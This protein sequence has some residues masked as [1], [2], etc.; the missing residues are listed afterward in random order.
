VSGELKKLIQSEALLAALV[1]LV[2][3]NLLFFPVIWGDKTLI[4]SAGDAASIMP[5]GAY[6]QNKE[7][8]Q[9]R[10]S[11][12]DGAP[13]WF[14]E[15]NY[16]L[17]HDCYFTRS[18]APLWNP[19]NGY[20]TPL[21]ANMQSQPFNPLILLACLQP[22]PRADDLFVLARLLL[23]G[24]LTN[25]YLRR[26]IGAYGAI[27]GA[28]AFMLTGY[29]TMFLN[30]PEISVSMWMPGL[31]YVLELLAQAVSFRRVVAAA[32]FTGMVLLGGM[33][34]VSFLV[35]LVGALYFFARI[36]NCQARSEDKSWGSLAYVLSSFCGM[37]IASPQILPFI[38]YVRESSNTHLGGIGAG[39][40]E[41][42]G[43]VFHGNFLVHFLNYLDPL[44][45]GPLGNA[46]VVTGVGYDGFNGYWGV[47][48]F[49][50]ALVAAV[51]AIE[52]WRAKDKDEQW[53]KLVPIVW[54]FI[55]L[56]FLFLGKKFGL[57][58]LSWIGTLPLFRLVVFWKYSEPILGFAMA[59]LSA[60]GFDQLV[61]GRLKRSS[62][63]IGFSIAAAVL[64]SVGL[65]DK[66]F[67]WGDHSVHLLFNKSLTISLALICAALAISFLAL[68]QPNLRMRSSRLLLLLLCANLSLSFMLPMFYWFHQLAKRQS[69]PYKG[70]PYI[71]FLQSSLKDSER[72][73]G[74]DGILFP[75][76]SSAFQICD[77]R[78]LD[79]LYPA[80]YLTFVRNFL[81]DK[82]PNELADFNLTTRF[83][84]MEKEADP[85]FAK[86]EMST[87]Q[88]FWYL[89]SVRYLLATRDHFLGQPTEITREILAHS[90]REQEQYLRLDAFTID[91]QTEYVL[92][93]H[94]RGDK[95]SDTVKY[96]CVV[97]KDKPWLDF[98]I[99]MDPS[100]YDIAYGDG[101][102]FTI[103]V[104]NKGG[105]TEVFSKYID[106]KSTNTD[107]HWFPESID[108]SKSVG[109]PMT[110]LF[111]VDG[112]PSHNTVGDW[113]GWADLH[114]STKGKSLAQATPKE[115]PALVYDK[116]I[117]V[118]K[119][120]DVLPRATMFYKFILSG[121]DLESLK[122][123][124]SKSFDVRST[125]VLDGKEVSSA[126]LPEEAKTSS[127][128]AL[129]PA[130]HIDLYSPLLVKV[131]VNAQHD[132]ILL[133][134]D[135]LYPGWNAY[136][137]G[138][139]TELWRGD[140]LFRAVYVK[141]GSHD[142]VFKYEPL[143]FYI[144]AC[145]CAFTVFAISAYAFFVGHRR[146]DTD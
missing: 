106:P 64:L 27:F 54:F 43:S 69:D 140:Y 39:G 28:I 57:P 110:L 80:R 6:E 56:V 24:I 77:V 8:K 120:A 143:S 84:G 25:L 44:I 2:L 131:S 68:V 15:P 104:S 49:A 58:L 139:R 17:L 119:T 19:Y 38:E 18:I 35:L 4:H 90:Q 107:R 52:N 102:K 129:T 88:R 66:R 83:H 78:D 85:L 86:A 114:F 100:V 3:L 34:E 11:N 112:G 95:V 32:F 125:L 22:S 113:S 123:L 138:K 62:L 10:R 135:Q 116:E 29:F 144:G 130:Q 61:T 51:A 67:L 132:G 117:K 37:A 5:Y 50:F 91:K 33:P 98:S 121:S 126:M 16:A 99:A 74:F 63:L 53:K 136:V 81:S 111:R 96:E 48:V 108:L 103:Y 137:D 45:Y 124:K 47:I 20:G 134:N 13:A 76:W 142:V 118:Y 46:K 145:A 105:E 7:N 122:L 12:D 109:T 1:L 79:A 26:F 133:L 36:L 71:Q 31:F 89:S 93:Q 101:V 30:M 141:E 115:A 73:L 94:P 42:P 146:R 9:S 70:A 97:D 23:A 60:I 87:L 21:L 92:F 65:F 82:E 14:S 128:P 59:T 55:A 40:S 127:S 41:G 75:N 72:V